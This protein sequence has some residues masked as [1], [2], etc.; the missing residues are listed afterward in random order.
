MRMSIS[1][2]LHQLCVFFPALP[3]CLFSFLICILRVYVL[4]Y[5]NEKGSQ[6]HI[7]NI[8]AF[9]T[10]NNISIFGFSAYSSFSLPLLVPVTQLT[11]PVHVN[12][13]C[14]YPLVSPDN[15]DY[16][17]QGKGINGG[18]CGIPVQ[19]RYPSS[20]YTNACTS[21]SCIYMCLCAC[22]CVC[23]CVCVMI[24]SSSTDI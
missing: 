6:A 5:C 2:M 8:P 10:N 18:S 21:V 13:E 14:P 12:I 4:L 3:L 17:I 9:S 20:A 24:V 11:H 23:V 15:F 22:V 19:S 7:I 16:I 1:C